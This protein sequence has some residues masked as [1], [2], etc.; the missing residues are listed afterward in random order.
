MKYV[1]KPVVVE[2]FQFG[3]DEEPTWFID[4]IF[5]KRIIEFRDL[6]GEDALDICSYD[7][8]NGTFSTIAYKNDMIIKDSNG[9][10]YPCE[11]EIFDA[12][13]E[14]IIGDYIKIPKDGDRAKGS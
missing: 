14:P 5:T 8:L 12:S 3:V 10:I 6:T 7:I 13:Y 1:K 2:A 4:K 9:K 11:K